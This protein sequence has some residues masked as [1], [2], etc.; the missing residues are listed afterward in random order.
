MDRSRYLQITTDF[1]FDNFESLDGAMDE[2]QLGTLRDW[3]VRELQRVE[4][5]LADRFDDG[6]VRDCHGDLHLANLVRLPDGIA[7]FDC[8]EFS[9]DLRHIDVF[10]DIAFLV[11]DLVER[12]RHDLAAHFLNRYLER[13]GDYGGVALLSLFFV[14]RCLVRAKVSVIRSRERDSGSDAEVDLEEAWQYCDMAE[15]QIAARPTF[16]VVMSGMSGSG[17]T[18]V[19]NELMAALPAIRLRSD[20]ERRRLFGLAETD[21]SHSAIGGGIYSAEASRKVYARLVELSREILASGHNVIID[22]AF[23]HRSERMSAIRLGDECGCSVVLLQII[24]PEAILRERIRQRA[25]DASEADLDVLEYQLGTAEPLDR[26][27]RGRA[28]I[29]ENTGGL[30]VPSLLQR[31]KEV[32]A[33]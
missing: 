3:T 33:A 4:S 17:K 13:S 25:A 11:M 20:I 10:C 14:Y 22:A 6:F 27:E 23:L 30:D 16:L 24:A 19:S 32:E 5:L 1:I 26:E 28:V 21:S 29:C 15:R 18:W 12:R 2:T 9:D 7:T 31:I 8:I